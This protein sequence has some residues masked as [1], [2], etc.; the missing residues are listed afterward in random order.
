MAKQQSKKQG[1]TVSKKSTA[2]KTAAKK[3]TPVIRD[4][5]CKA[6][7]RFIRVVGKGRCEC[8][9]AYLVRG[10]KLTRINETPNGCVKGLPEAATLKQAEQVKAEAKEAA[11]KAKRQRKDGKMSGLDAAAQVLAEADEPLG[12]QEIVKRMLEKGLW[13]TQ[14]RTPHATI[15]SGLLRNLQKNGEASR[16]RKVDR[17][18]FTVAK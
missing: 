6:C 13:E 18:R 16:F 12:C 4:G 10:G 9:Q 14:G 7:G 3:A 2:K 1:K 15:Y 5:V 11:P 8:G 17:G